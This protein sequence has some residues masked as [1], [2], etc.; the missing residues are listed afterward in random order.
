MKY[1]KVIKEIRQKKNLSQGELASMLNVTQTYLSQIEN[2]KRTPGSKFV[3][4]ISEKLNI[5]IY[6]FHF[7][8]IE[9]EKDIAS[10]KRD[11]YKKISPMISSMIEEFFLNEED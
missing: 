8:A 10:S 11:N 1:G 3:E 2:D 9:I 7:K 5:P 6:Y 4:T